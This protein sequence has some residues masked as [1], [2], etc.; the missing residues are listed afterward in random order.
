MQVLVVTNAFGGREKGQRITDEAEIK[1]IL[2]GEHAHHVVSADHPA[3][4]IE[5]E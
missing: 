4:H 5:Q 2:T 1:A 3:E